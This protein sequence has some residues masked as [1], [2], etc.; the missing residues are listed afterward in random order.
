MNKPK[1]NRIDKCRVHKD[2]DITKDGC[3]KCWEEKHSDRYRRGKCNKCCS[4]VTWLVSMNEEPAYNHRMLCNECCDYY[5]WNDEA[6]KYRES[7]LYQ[8]NERLKRQIAFLRNYH[9][10]Y[11]PTKLVDA[12]IEDVE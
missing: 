12:L 6:L 11:I 4:F 8:E 10:D 2:T 5:G 3:P 7:P 1:R 9:L